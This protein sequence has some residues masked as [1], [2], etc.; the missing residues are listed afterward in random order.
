VF[1]AEVPHCDGSRAERPIE[2]AARASGTDVR[3]VGVGP[4]FCSS[5]SGWIDVVLAGGDDLDALISGDH[6]HG[7]GV[8][9]S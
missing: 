3:G 1:V 8:V 6:H 5:R 2:D 9:S 4:A 7:G